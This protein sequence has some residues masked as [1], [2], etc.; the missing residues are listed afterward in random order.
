MLI[1]SVKTSNQNL[2]EIVIMSIVVEG[3]RNYIC[4]K[5]PAPTALRA[6]AVCYTLGTYKVLIERV[7]D[8]LWSV[9]GAYKVFME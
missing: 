3:S 4:K 9:L 7:V 8:M 1:I 5:A 6:G 2:E